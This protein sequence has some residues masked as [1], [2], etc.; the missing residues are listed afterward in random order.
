MGTRALQSSKITELGE[1]LIAAGYVRLDEQARV[2]GLS[3]STTW[4]IIR[5]KHKSSGLS[6][7]L[8]KRMLAQPRLPQLIRVKILEYVE[9]KSLGMY[10]HNASQVR[11]FLE[12]LAPIGP[13]MASSNFARGSF[14]RG[15]R[16]Q[17]VALGGG[18]D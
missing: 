14:A 12:A 11:R 8:I 1:A 18:A 3:R 17:Y 5:A 10:G 9:Q 16:A 7:S 2:L 15:G 4:T 6:G 13:V